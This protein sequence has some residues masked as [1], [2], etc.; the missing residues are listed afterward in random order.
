M[1]V[2]RD[3]NYRQTA[4]RCRPIGL[5]EIGDVSAEASAVFMNGKTSLRWQFP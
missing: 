1:Q 5:P 2:V 3:D 4:A